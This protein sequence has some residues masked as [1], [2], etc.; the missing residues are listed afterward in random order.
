MVHNLSYKRVLLHF[1][2]HA[3]TAVRT[4]YSKPRP[5]WL[6]LYV[7]NKELQYVDVI[8]PATTVLGPLYV[9]QL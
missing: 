1:G 7:K 4:K 9:Q 8:H 5:T 3:T 2:I 6:P